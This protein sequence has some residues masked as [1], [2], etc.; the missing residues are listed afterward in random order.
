MFWYV[1]GYISIYMS[2]TCSRMCNSYSLIEKGC[3]ITSLI[4][5]ILKL[6]S[7]LLKNESRGH[8]LHPLGPHVHWASSCSIMAVMD[9]FG[10]HL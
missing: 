3:L 7:A 8:N 10:F 1:I 4:L 6:R 2:C 5:V 9:N